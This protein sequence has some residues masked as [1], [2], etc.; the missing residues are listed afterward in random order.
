MAEAHSIGMLL[1]LFQMQPWFCSW[2]R[3]MLGRWIRALPF[4]PKSLHE[5]LGFARGVGIC[6]RAWGQ[7]PFLILGTSN[8]GSC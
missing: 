4:V 7:I 1:P 6:M 5:G 8:P 2:C 3:V